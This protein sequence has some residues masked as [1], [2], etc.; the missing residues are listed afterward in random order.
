MIGH[1]EGLKFTLST[2]IISGLRN[3][4]IQV[5]AA[6]SP[7]NSGGPVY[8][9]RGNLVGIVS[10]KFDHN[11]DANAENIGFAAEADA[12]LDSS[13]WSFASDGKKLLDRYVSA[14]K[15]QQSTPS[16]AE[17]QKP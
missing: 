7:G 17:K 1:P 10:S 13:H 9:D 4:I 3:Q 8:D 14:V 12:L 15:A 16:T 5:S 6:I 11:I 2:G